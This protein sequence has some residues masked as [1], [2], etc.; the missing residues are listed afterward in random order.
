MKILS[1]FSGLPRTYELYQHKVSQSIESLLTKPWPNENFR[2]ECAQTK[3]L[4]LMQTNSFL[5]ATI[6]E[7]NHKRMP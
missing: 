4:D 2:Y 1:N 7:K 5:A 3:F 6:S